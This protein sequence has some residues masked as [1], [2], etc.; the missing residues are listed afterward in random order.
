MTPLSIMAAT[1]A[2]G[3]TPNASDVFMTILPYAVVIILVAIAGGVIMMISRRK[4]DSA[5]AAGPVGF[6]LADL[7]ELRDRG[8]LSEE[9]F[10]RA[11]QEVI[12]RARKA[13]RAG[14]DGPAVR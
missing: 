7:K 8:E 2:P 1:P 12:A 14:G 13:F 10:E 9:E 4:I 11:R 3:G 6:T 5:A